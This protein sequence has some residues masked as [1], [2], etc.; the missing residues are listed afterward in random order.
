[1]WSRLSVDDE[2]TLLL[3]IDDTFS[4]KF[5]DA[6][7]GVGNFRNGS[8]GDI[9]DLCLVALATSRLYKAGVETNSHDDLQVP[10]TAVPES[11]DA[12]RARNRCLA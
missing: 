4:Q 2:D 6:T 10:G 3:I 12:V 5:A 8:T 9:E 11:A 7:D 1:V